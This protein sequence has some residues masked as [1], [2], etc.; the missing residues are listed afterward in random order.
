MIGQIDFCLIKCDFCPIKFASMTS[1][2]QNDIDD[3][4]VGGAHEKL[5]M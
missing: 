3:K 4:W 2:Y 5:K 1:F